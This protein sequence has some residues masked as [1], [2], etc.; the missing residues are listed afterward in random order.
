MEQQLPGMSGACPLLRLYLCFSLC[1]QSITIADRCAQLCVECY[2]Y[3]LLGCWGCCA[4]AAVYKL[5]LMCMIV[6]LH[7]CTSHT[8]QAAHT[9]CDYIV[10]QC[11]S[12]HYQAQWEVHCLL[13]RTASALLGPG[14]LVAR[15]CPAAACFFVQ[16]L[17]GTA[18]PI[19]S[20]YGQSTLC[21]AASAPR[22]QS[23]VF[24]NLKLPA[25]MLTLCIWALF[26]VKIEDSGREYKTYRG[27]RADL[28][29]PELKNR[30]GR[31]IHLFLG[32]N[33]WT[34]LSGHLNPD[35]TYAGT[36]AMKNGGQHLHGAAL[37]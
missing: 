10:I 13:Q 16:S 12:Y 2:W 14:W 36:L 22:Q 9:L 24:C 26:A 21:I 29:P 27:L 33:N 31:S 32:S 1:L 20:T 25:S 18:S 3:T 35:D 5:Q 17:L 8:S 6:H 15:S 11:I 19:M 23:D 7:H 37:M 34:S 30:P 28:E 4:L